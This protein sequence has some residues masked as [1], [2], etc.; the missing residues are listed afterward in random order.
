MQKFHMQSSEFAT[1]R[2]FAFGL[3][4]AVVA[5][6]LVSLGAWLDGP[7][8]TQERNPAVAE[9]AAAERLLS[10]GKESRAERERQQRELAHCNVVVSQAQRVASR[11]QP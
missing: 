3:V 10:W 2:N 4:G 11:V 1:E 9:A 8:P 7:D 5:V 6:L